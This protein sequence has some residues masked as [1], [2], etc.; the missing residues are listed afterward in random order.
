MLE[1]IFVSACEVHMLSRKKKKP[2]HIIFQ[3]CIYDKIKGE[4][5]EQNKC[6][7]NYGCFLFL[8]R[9]A[10]HFR[11]IPV[12]LAVAMKG[13]Q[14]KMKYSYFLWFF[15]NSGETHI[16]SHQNSTVWINEIENVR[17]KPFCLFSSICLSFSIRR[18]WSISTNI[19]KT[20]PNC[21]WSIANFSLI[22]VPFVQKDQHETATMKQYQFSHQ[23]VWI[24]AHKVQSNGKKAG[25]TQA[26][27]I[28]SSDSMEHIWLHSSH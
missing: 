27:T 6:K 11:L 9:I 22:T 24:S 2:N 13:T 23:S 5:C 28:D 12:S 16:S 19:V 14:R 4:Q 8:F 17:Q 20:N 26:I 7:H 1:Y 3:M 15:F 25:A 18:L 10:L 21:E